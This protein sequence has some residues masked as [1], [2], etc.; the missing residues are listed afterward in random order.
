MNI[1]LALAITVPQIV[2]CAG[3]EEQAAVFDSSAADAEFRW[4]A[5][6]VYQA[7]NMESCVP[8]PALRRAVVLARETGAVRAFERRMTATSL[9]FHLDVARSDAVHG[10]AADSGCWADSDPRFARRH[11]Q[12]A[13]NQV[14]SSLA[15]ME[16][17]APALADSLPMVRAFAP[18]AAEFRYFV[19]RLV[20]AS[21]PRCALS[22]TADN[23]V[24]MAP[25]QAE[26]SRFKHRLDGT[27]YAVHYDMAEAD[28]EYD[29]AISVVDCAEPEP[30]STAQLSRDALDHVRRQIVRI[31]AGLAATARRGPA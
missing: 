27:S 22:A 12:M 11:V 1:A 28:V 25:A 20:E 31:E 29:H 3:R 23:E 13:R 14:W 10:L 7:L 26:V 19:R 30:G 17:L 21:H 16:T 9:A 6:E 18:E 5:G 2:G 15:R 24:I 8:D 4:L